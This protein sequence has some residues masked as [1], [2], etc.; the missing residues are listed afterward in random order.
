MRDGAGTI[1]GRRTAPPQRHT[2]HTG[3]PVT[4]LTAGTARI[5]MQ[6]IIPLTVITL[7]VQSCNIGSRVV[8]S[9]F[10]IHL[11]ANPF[12]V[13]VLISVYAIF[14]TLIAVYSGRVSDRFGSYRPMIA[15]TALLGIG[16]LLPA[17]WPHITALYASAVLIGVGFIFF[18]VATQNLAGGLGSA[19]A[20]TGNFATLSL[21]YGGGHMVG[22]LVAGYSIDYSGFPAAYF[23]F[24]ALTAVAIILLL[25]NSRLR[26]A[27]VAVQREKASA[28]SLMR[29]PPLRRAIVVSALVTTGWDLYTFYVPIYGHSIGLSASAIGNVLAVFAIATLVVRI[30]LPSLTRRLG[31]EGVLSIAMFS[32]GVFFIA[33]PL[34]EMLALLLALSFGIG[35]ALGC[36]QPLTV[37]LA[38]NR[39][40]PGRSGEVVGLRLSINNVTHVVVPLAAGAVGT[41]L[42]V[43]PV[44]WA[45]AAI[46]AT[47]GHLSRHK[48]E[49]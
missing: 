16:L 22:P 2:P 34:T 20:R 7:V 46:L 18:N 45:S 6:P 26:V 10:A 33:F 1:A 11:G 27:P 37:N 8:A 38:Y 42:G 49:S 43:A 31:V 4:R 3:S 12:F 47:T 21:G 25:A 39:S 15:G 9:L 30:T 36:G 14:P 44:F 19:E 5:T 32:G 35:L 40:P 24:F 13:G 41:A 48:E 29:N 28:L 23:S 17:L